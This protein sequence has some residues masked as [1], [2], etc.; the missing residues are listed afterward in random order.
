[1]E[2]CET[3]RNPLNTHDGAK[4][5]IASS[6]DLAILIVVRVS[7]DHGSFIWAAAFFKESMRRDAMTGT[8]IVF[9]LWVTG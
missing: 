1:M 5:G 8:K 7:R 4:W 9:A 6:F 3:S 2:V